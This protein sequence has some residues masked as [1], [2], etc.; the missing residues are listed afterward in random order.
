MTPDVS[1][2]LASDPRFRAYEYVGIRPGAIHFYVLR[3]FARKTP[4]FVPE[5]IRRAH[6]QRVRAAGSPRP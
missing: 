4:R 2:L 1:R 3:E 6:L 5:L